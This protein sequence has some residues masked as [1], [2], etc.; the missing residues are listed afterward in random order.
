MSITKNSTYNLVGMIVPL[1]VSLITVPLYL[2][3][4]GIERYGILV[5]CWLMLGYLGFLEIGIGPALQ[6][7]VAKLR[8]APD[9]QRAD[10]FWSAMWLN[11]F[12]SLIG[13][14]VLF[15]GAK[16]YFSTIDVSS[17]ALAY[18]VSLATPWLAA[19]FPAVLLT[20]VLVSGL[21]GREEFLTANVISSTNAVVMSIAPLVVATLVGPRLDWLVATSLLARLLAVSALYS[22]CKTSIPFDR[23]ELPKMVAIKALLPF[24]GWVSATSILTPLVSSVDRFAI[25][26]FMGPAAVSIYV[27][28]FNLASRTKLIPQ[29]L[30]S[31]LFPRFAS[32][33]VSMHDRLEMDALGSVASIMTPVTLFAIAVMAPFLEIWIGPDLAA[34][35][36]SVGYIILVGWWLNSFA[37]VSMSR[38]L[39]TERPGLVTKL[40]LAQLP[41]YALLLYWLAK[42]MGVLGVAVAWTLRAAL[43]PIALMILTGTFRRCFVL[44]IPPTLLV[45]LAMFVALLTPRD[46]AGRWVGL[47]VLLLFGLIW[48]WKTAPE[49][50]VNLRRRLSGRIES[51]VMKSDSR[52]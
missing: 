24:G 44:L 50:L 46:S 39:G 5:L 40:L 42:S 43:D 8:N 4:I 37:R 26:S 13:V 17:A 18:E 31:A 14:I 48:A 22:R 36:A 1:I 3:V 23:P 2:D 49:P 6:Q 12:A 34:K 9:H 52:Q 7:R 28:P 30:A 25:G 35:S 10:V 29:A 11:L 45:V 16:V 21:K 51:I 20:S 15:Y 32:T 47:G 27:I 33:D 19:I 38:L 41:F